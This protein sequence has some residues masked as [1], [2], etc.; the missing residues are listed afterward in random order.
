MKIYR[1]LFVH[2]NFQIML[3]KNMLPITNVSCTKLLNIRQQTTTL[4]LTS[5]WKRNEKAP[6]K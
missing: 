5:F 4:N 2:M 1:S 3:R 6:N